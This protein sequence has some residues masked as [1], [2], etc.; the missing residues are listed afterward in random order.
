[1]EEKKMTVLQVEGVSKKYKKKTALFPHSFQ[2]EEGSCVAL[3]GG[4]G[5]G[6][7][8]LLKIIAR[9]LFPSSGTVSINGKGISFDSE[10]Y[11][12]EIGF[13]PDDFHAQELMTVAEF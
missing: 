13:M 3:C 5:A 1:M 8:T 10:N 6:K 7:S 4:N 11:L 2:V 12:K 9:A